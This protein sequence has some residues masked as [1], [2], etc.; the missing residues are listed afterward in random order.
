MTSAEN[1]NN[2]TTEPPGSISNVSALLSSFKHANVMDGSSDESR[3]LSTAFQR[4]KEKTLE[5]K[6]VLSEIIR[7]RGSKTLYEYAQGYADVNVNPLLLKRQGEFINTL[8]QEIKKRFGDQV[9]E[10]AA[11]QLAQKYFVFTHAHHGPLNSRDVI[12]AYL[13]M[14][15]LNM[16]GHE[17]SHIDH[18]I[19][20]SCANI[21]LNNVEFPRGLLAHSW[22]GDRTVT[23][24]LSFLPSTA[25]ASPVYNFRSYTPADVQKIKSS[26]MKKVHSG[27]IL[28]AQA[29]TL[30]AVL[31]EIYS[32][33]SALAADRFTDQVSITNEM[34]W[35]KICAH[36][37][38]RQLPSL[39]YLEQEWIVA[40]LL[41]NH[42]LYADTTI[43]HMLFD[44]TYNE[45]IKKYFDDIYGAFSLSQK[46]G[47][48][49]FWALPQGSKYRLQL[50]KDGR[51]LSTQDGSYRVA[52]NPDALR[53]ALE[54][55]ELMPNLHLTFMVLAL[56]YGIKCLGGYSQVNYLTFMKQAY[57]K[58][59]ADRGNFKSVEIATRSQTKEWAGYT[60]AFLGFPNHTISPATG[61]DL[62]LY[63]NGN[64]WSRLKELS[65]H[66]NLAEA[67][68]PIL[69][70]CYKYS[71]KETERDP[72]LLKITEND[73]TKATHLDQIISP[74]AMVG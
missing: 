28:R 56:Y 69:P 49:F 11:E 23:H 42:H 20:L 67:L 41:I 15:S 48:F 4:L 72:E 21:S 2:E 33:S 24:R 53:N 73:V 39:L 40:R 61:L 68:N 26:I 32:T 6:P 60:L 37:P 54:R 70:E 63:G 65:E 66:I 50:W 29:V 45:L 16:N 31:D 55:R 7:E 12:N 36:Y 9:A 47:T 35:Q 58:L 71:Y 44:P 8:K 38:G 57:I 1:S 27:E 18:L 14:A 59:Q 46:T 34:L 52:L 25:H 51:Y 13:L 10:T 62:I 43:T 3:H 22:G 5:R 64:M 19:V 74:C 30:D 17:P